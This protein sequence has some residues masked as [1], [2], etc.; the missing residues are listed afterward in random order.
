MQPA[1]IRPLPYRAEKGKGMDLRSSRPG[2]AR[3]PN[4]TFL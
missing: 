1:G 2:L 3:G 4:S